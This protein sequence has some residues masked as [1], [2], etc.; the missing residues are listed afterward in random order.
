VGGT[1]RFWPREHGL[2][3]APVP[4]CFGASIG[5]PGFVAFAL[6]FAA[7]CFSLRTSPARDA[8]HRGRAIARRAGYRRASSLRAARDG[9]GTRGLAAL[10][11]ASSSARLLA[12]VPQPSAAPAA[13][14]GRETSQVA[15]RRADRG[16]GLRVPPS[17]SRTASGLDGPALWGPPIVWFASFAAGT[18]A[19]TPSR[20]A[21]SI[22][23]RAWSVPQPRSRSSWRWPPRASRS[24]GRNCAGS[25][26]RLS[27]RVRPQWP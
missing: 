8:R 12:L 26:S 10:Y 7:C 9:G 20:R 11:F 2:R 3:G 16:R 23:T 1:G 14:R 21:S 25:A 15:R 24:R 27:C 6:A 17:P 18:F 22:A 19:C 4:H 5:R 13:A